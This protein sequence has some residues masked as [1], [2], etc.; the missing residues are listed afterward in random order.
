MG[1]R[2]L[3]LERSNLPPVTGALR[4]GSHRLPRDGRTILT[5]QPHNPECSADKESVSGSRW[6]PAAPSTPPPSPVAFAPLQ[7]NPS[8][9]IDPPRPS[10]VRRDR[11]KSR[12]HHT[13]LFKDEGAAIILLATRLTPPIPCF[14][15]GGTGLPQCLS[16]QKNR[17]PR[18]LATSKKRKFC[19]RTLLGLITPRRRE[20]RARCARGASRLPWRKLHHELTPAHPAF[21]VLKLIFHK[22]TTA[23]GR[24]LCE[25][26]SRV[27]HQLQSP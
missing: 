1:R 25:A 5:C 7:S 6:L 3:I 26:H 13:Q 16:R 19:M 23:R 9:P 12:T 18:R 8:G 21:W 24:P 10:A 27:V 2:I 11:R 17:H 4:R 15:F 20:K 22:A 14:G